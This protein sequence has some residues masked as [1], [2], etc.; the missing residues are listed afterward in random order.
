MPK[1]LYKISDENVNIFK[2]EIIMASKFNHPSI[3]KYLGFN[4]FNLITKLKGGK[5]EEI[6]PTIIMEFIPNRNLEDKVENNKEWSNTDRLKA[7]IGLA[8]GLSEMYDNQVIHRD[9]KPENILLNEKNEPVICDLGSSRQYSDDN[10]GS[11]ITL[12]VGTPIQMAPELCTEMFNHI[13]KCEVD[14]YS[15]GIILY[16]ILT[17]KPS[18]RVYGKLNG[19]D[20]LIEKKQ[21]NFRPELPEDMCQVFVDLINSCWN[22][23]VDERPKPPKIYQ[24]LVDAV[25]DD[26]VVLLPDVNISE[27]KEYI[28]RLNE[29]SKK[30]D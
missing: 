20:D 13:Y 22:V 19:L 4:Q 24:K 12:G 30:I 28:S 3:V 14:S 7:I 8:A 5:L 2:R 11:S 18:L 23:M 1:I 25:Y 17:L 27:V 10:R 26:S 29:A 21:N 6:E 15:F 9:L 16:Q